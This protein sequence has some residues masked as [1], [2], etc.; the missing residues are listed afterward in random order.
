M[1]RGFRGF[2]GLE[3]LEGSL[4]CLEGGLEATLLYCFAVILTIK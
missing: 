2:G 1:F 4:E 3:C